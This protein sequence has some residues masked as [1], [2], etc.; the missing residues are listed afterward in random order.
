MSTGNTPN[1]D[2]ARWWKAPVC[3]VKTR[4]AWPYPISGHRY[5]ETS[6]DGETQRLECMT[7]TKVSEVRWAS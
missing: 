4:M 5:L 7:C 3:W 2:G 1:M 6:N